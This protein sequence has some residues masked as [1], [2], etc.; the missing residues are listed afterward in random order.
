M[1]RL[2][3]VMAGGSQQPGAGALRLVDELHFLSQ[4]FGQRSQLV[5]AAHG[6]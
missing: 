1:H 5:A 6:V 3:Q 4:P 2:P